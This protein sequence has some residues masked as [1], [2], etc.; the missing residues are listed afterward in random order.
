[1]PQKPPIQPPPPDQHFEPTI[2]DQQTH[3]IG[4]VVVEFSKLEGVL[5]DLI[6]FLLDI[7][8]AAG[9][10]VTKRLDAESKLQMLGAL[11]DLRIGSPKVLIPLKKTLGNIR[12]LKDNRNFIAHGT[13]GQWCPRA[14]PSRFHSSRR[15]NPEWSYQRPSLKNE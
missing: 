4:R 13:W 1:M 14:F 10:I 6:W 8:E 2:S 3:M 11:A 9:R 15:L 5:E 7:D 12:E